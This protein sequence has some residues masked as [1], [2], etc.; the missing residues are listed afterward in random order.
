MGRSRGTRYKDGCIPPKRR[1]KK[2]R[3]PVRRPFWPVPSR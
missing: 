2:V 1:D 3:Y